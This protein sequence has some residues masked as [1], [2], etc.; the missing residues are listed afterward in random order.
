MDKLRG[1][2]SEAE[3]NGVITED[4]KGFVITLAERFR[5]DIA[6]KMKEL[7]IIQ[8]EIIQLK[9][10]EKIITDLIRGFILAD[11]RRREMEKTIEKN[12]EFNK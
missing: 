5:E 9:N 3:G 6:K 12:I 8:G 7:T 4:E 10:N 11:K 2:I 1:I